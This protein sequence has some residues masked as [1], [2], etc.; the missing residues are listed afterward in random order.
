MGTALRPIGHEDRLSLVDH[1]T[2]LRKRLIISI[3]TLVV[4]FGFCFWQNDA[5]L[6][7]V[8]KPVRDT[9]NLDNPN[10][11][12]KDP[13]EQ[14]ALFQKQMGEALA[15]TAPALASTARTFHALGS[16][17]NLTEAQQAAIT[18]NSQQLATAG[19]EV[20]QAAAAL[21]K[22][23]G[24][25]LVTLGVTEPF[26]ATITVAF[27]CALLLSMPMLLYQ[28]YAFVLPAFSPRERRVALPLML[29]V[30]VLFIAGV[31]FGYFVVLERAV[32]FLQ[33]FND[34][35]FDI[36]LQ[37]KE[38]FKFT[39]LFIGGIGLLFQIPVGVLAVTRLGILTPKQLARNRGYVILAI[40]ILAA[41]ATPTP[42]PVTMTLAMLPLVVLFEL[43][44][45]LARW[46]D[47]IKPAA[48]DV[49]DEHDH[50]DAYDGADDVIGDWDDH[51]AGEDVAP[52]LQD[53]E[54]K[55]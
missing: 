22:N 18:K 38:Y 16:A 26:T 14:A 15:A 28:A 7:I 46:F 5:L 41:V 35:S 6:E 2:E 44:I 34:D 17:E 25:N 33:N 49:D 30:P 19:R 29:M 9:Q 51:S 23:T 43:S 8:T 10:P 4:A 47:R 39:V 13:L 32:H 27:Y 48:A 24:R 50:E 54:P 36:L 40:S 53:P 20:A 45:I 3:V 52:K 37:A 21:P 42:D 55:D 12:T 1:L 31:L 11:S